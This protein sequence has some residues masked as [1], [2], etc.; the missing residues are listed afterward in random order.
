[1]KPSARQLGDNAKLKSHF[2]VTTKVQCS[3]RLAAKW[4][5]FYD[6]RNETVHS[7]GGA[8]GFAVDAVIS[9]MEFMELNAEALKGVLARTLASWK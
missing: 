9:Y 7:L 3:F 6:H 2:G 1:M 4:N 5:E 8:S